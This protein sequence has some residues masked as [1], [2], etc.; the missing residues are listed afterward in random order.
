MTVPP[1]EE[2][3]VRDLPLDALPPPGA[4]AVEPFPWRR[5]DPRML[6]VH[7]VLELVRFLPVLVGVFVLGSSNN[8]G[9][10]WQLFSVAVP[11]AVG[12][13]RFLTTRFR[14][15]PRQVELQRGL[16]SKKVLTARLD[17]VR[18][19]EVT[20]SP[21]HRILGLA[22]VEIGTASGAKQVDDK[23]V[24]DGLP[25]QQARQ[26]RIALLH[27]T[28]A[29][30]PPGATAP[31]QVPPATVDG[32]AYDDVTLLGFDRRW[33]RY[34]PLTSSGNVIAAGVV[35]I[36]GQF[37]ETIGNRLIHQFGGL[38][39]VT[40]RPIATLVPVAV[41][42]GL[43][44]FLLL[45]AVFSVLGYLI[46]NWGFTLSR[47]ARGRTFH[48]RRGLLTTTETS[49]ERERVRGL[50]VIE[51]LGLRLVGAARLAAIVTGVSQQESGSSLLVP[52]APREV[53]DA[54]G[55]AVLDTFEPLRV[56]LGQHGPAARRRRYTRALLGAAVLPAGALVLALGTSFPW[57]V[58]PATLVLLPVAALLAADRYRRLGHALDEGYLVVRSGSL[59]GRRDVLQ[60][61]GI[62]GWNVHQSWFQRRSGLVTLV[63]TTAAGKQAYA[64]IDIPE[65]RAIA[66]ADAAVPGLVT[67]FLR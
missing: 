62:I 51:P 47:D 52:P 31:G 25:L 20:S 49:L 1:R 13:V 12:I 30:T 6:L 56:E 44:L 45:G 3:P 5:L 43:L 37:S 50:E 38:G 64:A 67:P 60:R 26:M 17:R 54:A 53:I 27:R 59:R 18:A 14:I 22:K 40:G 36:L 63:A 21:I 8:D 65:D 15:T 61:S 34:A 57:W 48:I 66:L 55:A 33:V 23:F 32:S 24:L 39:W 46:T 28:Q 58:A 7:P 42:G 29:G 41:L 10:M 11:V 19:V 2:P 9:G 16:L 4:P 35:A